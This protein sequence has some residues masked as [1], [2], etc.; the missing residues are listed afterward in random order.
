MVQKFSGTLRACD[1][2]SHIPPISTTKVP[3]T[4]KF[5]IMNNKLFRF[6]N[7]L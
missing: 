4:V 3:R 6:E 2:E 1:A 7:G 5:E